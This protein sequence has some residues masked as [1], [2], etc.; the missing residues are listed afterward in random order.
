M[1]GEAKEIAC[2]RTVKIFKSATYVK[3]NTATKTVKK[4]KRC[5][6]KGGRCMC[7]LPIK[8]TKGIKITDA[9]MADLNLNREDY[10]G[11]WNYTISPQKTV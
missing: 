8:A 9:Q 3:I 5:M 1:Y 2:T 7:N 10:H 4:I 11:E 6:L